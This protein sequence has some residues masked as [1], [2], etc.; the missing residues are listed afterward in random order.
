MDNSEPND[1]NLVAIAY[2]AVLQRKH[3]DILILPSIRLK[4]GKATRSLMVFVLIGQKAII[5]SFQTGHGTNMQNKRHL[6]IL[7][8][9]SSNYGTFRYRTR[10]SVRYKQRKTRSNI[11]IQCGISIKYIFYN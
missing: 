2:Q 7:G 3:T 5:L 4:R 1:G 6:L 11:R 8:K 9:R 10:T